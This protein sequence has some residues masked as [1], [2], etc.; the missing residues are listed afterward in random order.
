MSA[1]AKD[2]R[3]WSLKPYSYKGIRSTKVVNA[4]STKPSSCGKM[5]SEACNVMMT[6]CPENVL[7]RLVRDCGWHAS[8]QIVKHTCRN[9]YD[10]DC[11]VPRLNDINAMD[12]PGSAEKIAA[13]LRRKVCRCCTL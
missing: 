11:A 13:S 8:I 6:L 9:Q 12:L 4:M 5:A 1:K 7:V 10:A 3:C 2:S